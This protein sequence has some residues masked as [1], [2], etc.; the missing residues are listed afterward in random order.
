MTFF[1]QHRHRI[2]DDDLDDAA[3]ALERD[4][5]TV[6]TEKTYDDERQK[7]AFS[8]TS[9]WLNSLAL[10]AA[11]TV[12]IM[13]HTAQQFV[14]YLFIFLAVIFVTTIAKNTLYVYKKEVTRRLG[15]NVYNNGFMFLTVAGMFFFYLLF[16]LVRSY[17]IVDENSILFMI[18]AF[19]M[20]ISYANVWNKDTQQKKILRRK[21]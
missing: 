19:G 20:Y 17:F 15:L 13:V 2:V 3:E 16:T 6:E 5:V 1:D 21:E 7:L 18:I 11:N 9:Q 4:W 8:T 12:T 10:M 14:S